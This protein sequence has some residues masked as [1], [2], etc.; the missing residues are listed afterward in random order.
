MI[1]LDKVMIST[2][3][4]RACAIAPTIGLYVAPLSGTL[5]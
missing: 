4:A 2:S 1:I 5:T 3:R